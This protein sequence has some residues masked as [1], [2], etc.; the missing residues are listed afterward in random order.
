MLIITYKVA[1]IALNGQTAVVS[2]N[3]YLMVTQLEVLTVGSGGA[4]AG[5][6]YAGIGTITTGVPATQYLNILAGAGV[7]RL[8][9]FVPSGY[10]MISNNGLVNNGTA[11]NP[12]TVRIYTKNSVT[13]PWVLR[14]RLVVNGLDTQQTG[15]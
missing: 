12:C 2:T 5:V 7:S 14:D 13:A 4:N 10:T 6:I 15:N 9:S 1:L 3:T 8:G 11:T